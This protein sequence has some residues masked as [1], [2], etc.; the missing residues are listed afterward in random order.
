M[1]S[2]DCTNIRWKKFKTGNYIDVS[3]YE[4]VYIYN[5]LILDDIANVSSKCVAFFLVLITL[6][7]ITVQSAKIAIKYQF[8]CFFK[9]VHSIPKLHGD[10]KIRITLGYSLIGSS[11]F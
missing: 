2:S 5:I 4:N 6:I 8:L 3:S 7:K 9:F 11:N 10:L 1:E